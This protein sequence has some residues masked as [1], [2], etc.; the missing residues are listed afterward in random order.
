[1]EPTPLTV[2]EVRVQGWRVEFTKTKFMTRLTYTLDGMTG[3]FKVGS[4]APSPC[5]ARRVDYAAVTV[6]LSAAS[7]CLSCSP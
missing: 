5:R 2:K 3:S 7:A 1:M 6:Q 4:T